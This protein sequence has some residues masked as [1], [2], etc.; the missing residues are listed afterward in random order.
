[1]RGGRS[2]LAPC[3][4]PRAHKIELDWCGLLDVRYAPNSGRVLQRNEMTEDRRQRLLGEILDPPFVWSPVPI[5]TS[6]RAP[7]EPSMMVTVLCWLGA[8]FLGAAPVSSLDEAVVVALSSP[9]SL[10]SGIRMLVT[11]SLPEEMLVEAGNTN[12][13]D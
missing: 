9:A 7:L 5:T 8:A 2:S 13:G 1:M 12:K 4:N 6:W 10:N 11:G 3:D